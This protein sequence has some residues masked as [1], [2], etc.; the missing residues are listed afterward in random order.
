MAG[1][2]QALP[3]TSQ[4]A[5]RIMRGGRVVACL[6]DDTLLL[7]IGAGAPVAGQ[8]PAQ[9]NDDPATA[10]SASIIGWRLALQPP[11]A[12]HGFAALLPINDADRPLTT[13]RLGQES[14]PRRYIFGPARLRFARA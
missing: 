10:T 6:I 1:A 14:S 2:E 13:L 7:V 3:Q 8:V 9:V 11:T 4:T 5:A 12:T